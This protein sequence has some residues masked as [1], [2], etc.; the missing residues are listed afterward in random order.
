M[1]IATEIELAASARDL[2]AL[3]RA[4]EGHRRE[5]AQ[6]GPVAAVHAVAVDLEPGLSGDEALRRI[7][8]SCLDQELRNEAAVLAGI[9]EGIHQMRVAVRRLRA[10][11]SAFRRVLPDDQQ[12]A[13]SDE[14]CWLA[15]ALG[16]ARNLDVFET[17]LLAPARSVVAEPA[18]IAALTAAVVRRRK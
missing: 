6:G 18:G 3:A 9:A 5:A 11:L 2:P 15:D 10:V 7:G 17:S 14:L 13:A 16:P 4:V 1:L 12:R 8:T